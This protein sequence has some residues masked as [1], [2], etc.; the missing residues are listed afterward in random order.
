MQDY[1]PRHA[2]HAQ[3]SEL[4]AILRG[5]ADMVQVIPSK[6]EEQQR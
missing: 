3:P 4:P 6:D 1:K 2:A 5:L